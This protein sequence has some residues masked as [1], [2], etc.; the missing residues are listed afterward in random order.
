MIDLWWKYF[1]NSLTGDG[2]DSGVGK[3]Y[4]STLILTL[5]QLDNPEYI[6]M[7]QDVIERAKLPPFNYTFPEGEEV[8]FGQF[9]HTLV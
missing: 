6:Q 1:C 8:T 4:E 7:A 9:Y 3:A 5:R 2:K